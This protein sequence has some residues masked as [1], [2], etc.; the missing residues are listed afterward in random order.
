MAVK[1]YSQHLKTA[2]SGSDGLKVVLLTNDQGNKLKAEEN[3]LAVYKCKVHS[4]PVLTTVLK[5]KRASTCH[6]IFFSFYIL[7][8]E[9]IKSLIGNPELVDCLALSNDDKVGTTV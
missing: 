2:E 6:Y 5:M 9:Y 3:G 4:S 1:W 7:V 8:D